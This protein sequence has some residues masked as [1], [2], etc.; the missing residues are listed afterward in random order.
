MSMKWCPLDLRMKQLAGGHFWGVKQ[1]CHVTKLHGECSY[2]FKI[3]AV[4]K[5]VVTREE[6]GEAG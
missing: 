4:N 6:D 5:T 2:L 3:L 1:E